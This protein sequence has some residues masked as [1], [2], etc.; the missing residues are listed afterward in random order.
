[1][2]PDRIFV[3]S[4][5]AACKLFQSRTVIGS[6]LVED[7]E[8]MRYA[9]VNGGLFYVNVCNAEGGRSRMC[10]TCNPH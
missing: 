10:E 5:G 1:M 8:M 7:S 3:G 4:L 2:E 6:T 9:L